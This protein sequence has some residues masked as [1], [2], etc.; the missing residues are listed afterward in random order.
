MSLKP[1][2]QFEAK[3]FLARLAFG[4]KLKGSVSQALFISS[5]DHRGLSL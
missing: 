3:S 1:W 4:K 5:K 2:P